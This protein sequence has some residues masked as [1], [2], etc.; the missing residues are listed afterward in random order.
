MKRKRASRFK[1]SMIWNLC[2]RLVIML[3]VDKSHNMYHPQIPNQ[4]IELGLLSITFPRHL[5]HL[6]RLHKIDVST[7]RWNPPS[8]PRLYD[9]RK[10]DNFGQN[11]WDKSMALL[12]KYW[13][14]QWELGELLGTWWTHIG[15]RKKKSKPFISSI[16]QIH[17]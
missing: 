3:V 7:R 9:W 12:R 1:L 16:D 10:E 2:P 15:S 5:F 8:L 6:W 4:C 14:T 13:G 17:T 11:I